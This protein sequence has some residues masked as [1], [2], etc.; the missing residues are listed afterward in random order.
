MFWLH[1]V[2]FRYSKM[3]C[4]SA[5]TCLIL[6]LIHSPPVNEKIYGVKNVSKSFLPSHPPRKCSTES[7]SLWSGS[8]S[9]G[10]TPTHPA[11]IPQNSRCLK[12]AAA[13]SGEPVPSASGTFPLMAKGGH[14][15]ALKPEVRTKPHFSCLECWATRTMRW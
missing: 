14:G 5:A 1:A 12:V 3:M 6:W 2:I 8:M 9:W 4:L 11:T 10:T 15:E 13:A 7:V